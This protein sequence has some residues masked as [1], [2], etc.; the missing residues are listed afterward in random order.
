MLKSIFEENI[1]VLS[2]KVEKSTSYSVVRYTDRED[3]HMQYSIEFHVPKLYPQDRI[4]YNII[5]YISGKGASSALKD[6]VK[7]AGKYW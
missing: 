5:S 1:E 7:T 3:E 4:A 6:S 2:Q